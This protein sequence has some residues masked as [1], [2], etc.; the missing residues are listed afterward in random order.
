MIVEFSIMDIIKFV[1]DGNG[2]ARH[3]IVF[4]DI[5]EHATSLSCLY[6]SDGRSLTSII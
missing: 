6:T 5:C 4:S 1:I 2:H 3:N